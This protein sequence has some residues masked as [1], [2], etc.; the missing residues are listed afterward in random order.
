MV[1]N[2]R[3]MHSL[4][5]QCGSNTQDAYF[6]GGRT[7]NKYL[8]LSPYTERAPDTHSVRAC[9]SHSPGY[10]P[11]DLQSEKLVTRTCLAVIAVTEPTLLI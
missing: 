5:G 11:F 10:F 4:H 1:P 2:A 6:T 9:R 8:N 3:C 7:C